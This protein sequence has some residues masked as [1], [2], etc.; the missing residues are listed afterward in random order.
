MVGTLQPE[1]FLMD[2]KWRLHQGQWSCTHIT[3]TQLYSLEREINVLWGFSF[4]LLFVL[5]IWSQSTVLLSTSLQPIALPVTYTDSTPYSSTQITSK[6]RPEPLSKRRQSQLKVTCL[7][8]SNQ[9]LHLTVSAAN[10]NRLCGFFFFLSSKHLLKTVS[11]NYQGAICWKLLQFT[12]KKNCSAL[13]WCDK[14][15]KEQFP[16]TEIL[17]FLI[18]KTVKLQSYHTLVFFPGYIQS[19]FPCHFPIVEVNIHI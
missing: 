19:N 3:K 8:E 17:L 10:I 1:R 16:N 11:H 6:P 13:V 2:A 5:F 15:A 18:L 9:I 14:L 12:N 7:S 4:V